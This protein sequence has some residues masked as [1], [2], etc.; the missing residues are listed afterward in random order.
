MYLRFGAEVG[1][2]FA[3]H[4]AFKLGSQLGV[5]LLVSCKAAVPRGFCGLAFG[6]GIPAC[7]NVGRGFQRVRVAS[8]RLCGSARFLPR[9]RC[10][11]AA[12][13]ALFVGRAKADGGFAAN[14]GGLIPGLALAVSIACR[15]STGSWCLLLR[16]T[17]QP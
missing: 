12:F 2:Q 3:C 4:A 15:I 9:L 10:A 16:M 13:G 7:T 1:G 8:L 11:V 5:G 17:C 14:Q 6:G